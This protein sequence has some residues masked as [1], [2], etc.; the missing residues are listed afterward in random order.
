MSGAKK[1]YTGQKH[2]ALCLFERKLLS[3]FYIAAVLFYVTSFRMEYSM[4]IGEM[5]VV[6][7]KCFYLKQIIALREMKF[8]K[9]FEFD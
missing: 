2:V 4:S 8:Y 6:F 7:S 9:H 1:I 3:V 5:R